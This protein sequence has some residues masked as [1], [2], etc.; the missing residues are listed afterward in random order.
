M[1]N[2]DN[3]KKP[4]LWDFMADDIPQNQPIINWTHHTLTLNF[5]N[6]MA[7]ADMNNQKERY[8]KATILFI[9]MLIPY[10]TERERLLLENDLAKLDYL[11]ANAKNEGTEETAKMQINNLKEDFANA[12]RAL[13]FLVFNRCGIAYVSDDG[14]LDF[15]KLSLAQV[16]QIIQTKFSG[17]TKGL[18]NVINK[19]L[20]NEVAP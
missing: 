14:E 11:I 18:E 19:E 9:Q 20:S 1:R 2:A 7:N 8:F 16:Q 15:D 12:H 4:Y 6:S 10:L 13:G 5:C 3:Q 17:D